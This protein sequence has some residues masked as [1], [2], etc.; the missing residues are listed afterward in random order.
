MSYKTQANDLMKTLGLEFNPIA[1]TFSNSPHPEGIGDK[2]VSV[3]KALE[4]ALFDKLIL[5]L[6]KENLLCIGGKF[7]LGLDKLPLSVG[8]DIWTEY[9]KAF[10]SKKVTIWQIV[11][12]PKPPGFWPWT[13]RKQKQFVVINPL[14]NSA[15]NPHVVLICCDPDQADKITGLLAFTG[16]GPIK[17]YP[18]NSICMPVAYPYVTGKTTISFLSQHAREMFGLKIPTGNLFVSV[19]YKDLRKALGPIPH[20]GYGTA[21][22]RKLTIKIMNDMLE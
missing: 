19:A 7:Y 22:T 17:Y 4:I 11:R 21:E 2:Q 5:N 15:S 6:S 12:G 18:A 20:S 9:H 1:I 8:I 3:C 10:K 13:K 14:E 16:H